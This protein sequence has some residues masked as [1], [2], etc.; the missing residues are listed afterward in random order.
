MGDRDLARVDGKGDGVAEAIDG[1]TKEVEADKDVSY[2][3]LHVWLVRKC[4]KPETSET[5]RAG[6]LF[7]FFGR[8]GFNLGVLFLG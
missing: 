1:T 8:V 6:F 4:R 3:F 7:S 5:L 2:I